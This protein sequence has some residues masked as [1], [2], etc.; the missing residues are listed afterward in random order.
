MFRNIF[1][2]GEQPYSDDDAEWDEFVRHHPH[3]SFLQTAQWGRLKGRFGWTA[4]RVWVR[5]QGKLVAGAQILFRSAAFGLVKMGYIPHG[6]VVDWE[7]EELTA[8]LMNYIDRAVYENRAGLLKMEPMLW[9]R[10]VSAETWQTRCTTHNLIPDTDTVQPPRTMLIDLTPDE[11][12]IL[13]NF[14]SK[15]RYNI[16]LAGRKEVT[17][18][19]ATE[20]DLPAFNALMK[21]TGNRNQ[22]GVH[23]SEYYRDCYNFFRETGDATILLAEFEG[24]PLAGVLLIQC[25]GQ[26]VYLAGGSSNEERNRMP[27][28]AIQWAAIQWARLCCL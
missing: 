13:K 1:Q 6:P 21:Q 20:A 25:G 28:Y 15:T 26:C 22:F 3:G 24:K 27:T 8:I 14:K 2:L 5:D 12:T 4:Y 16:R 10:D 9:Q 23:S 18:R 17:V 11:D 7:N 19:E